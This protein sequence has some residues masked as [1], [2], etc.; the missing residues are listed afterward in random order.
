MKCKKCDKR[1]SFGVK[2]G[3]QEYCSAHKLSFHVNIY[4]ALCKFENCTTSPCFGLPD[5]TIAEYCN[6]HRPIGY[7]DVKSKKCMY[8]DCTKSPSFG[9]KGTKIRLFCALH[10]GNDH[11]NVARPCCIYQECTKQSNYGEKGT[12]QPLY[13]VS[14][15]LPDHI[16]VTSQMCNAPNCTVQP[17]YGIKGSKK[18]E[19]CFTHKPDNY[20]NVKYKPCQASNCTTVPIFGVKGTRKAIYCLT[21][22]SVDHVRVKN[23]CLHDNCAISPCYGVRGIKTTLYCHEHKLPEH[24]NVRDKTCNHVDNKTGEKCGTRSN[25]GYAGYCPEY[26]TK[27]KFPRMVIHPT[28]EQKDEDIICQYCSIPIHYDEEFCSGCKQYVVSEHVSLK[29]KNKEIA[30]KTLL[31]K[32]KIK[33]IYDKR[34]ENG[35]SL[36]RPDFRFEISFGNIILEIDEFQ[37][38]R[39]TYSCECE[40]IRMKQIYYD[41][42]M[43]YLLFI[44]YNPDSYKGVKITDSKRQQYLVKYL[45]EQF[46]NKTK[47]GLFVVYLFYDHFD[48]TNPEIETIN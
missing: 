14:H 21:H 33:Y 43:P 42:G 38:N 26:C 23:L 41:C 24:I 10:K 2:G 6:T 3:K 40:I 39:A 20:V 8:Q 11:V 45:R 32:Q 47:Q 27:H 29:L 31:D 12:K 36:K 28:K 35:C 4:K 1:A 44:R 17:W 16:N 5:S 19:Y 30:I 7:V 37:H 13:C 34:V 25:Y 22:K 18:A 9:V 46:E 48:M 15:K